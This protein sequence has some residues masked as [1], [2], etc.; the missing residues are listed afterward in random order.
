MADPDL[1]DIAASAIDKGKSA[2]F[3]WR[4]A[5][6]S[7]AERLAGLRN[8]V[9]AAR[10]NDVRDVGQRVLEE[11]TA[12]R[13]EKPEI[14][15]ETILVAE[16]LTPSDTATLDRTR[17]VGFAT[18]SGGASSHVAIIA[19]S[20]DIPAVAGIESRALDIADG[21]RVVLDGSKGSLQLNQSDAQ[22]EAIVARQQR[23]A[24][25]KERDLA[26]AGEPATT[27]NGIEDR[28]SVV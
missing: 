9:L 27:T 23:I 5:F 18:T 15:P 2:P 20:L 24:A 26:N 8:E 12:Q 6:S 14:P 22:I 3:A 13:R 28:K 21:T 25:K 16:D 11:L 4:G 19:R 10:A 7:Y 17:V 1:L